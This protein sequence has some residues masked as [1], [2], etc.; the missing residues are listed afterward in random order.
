MEFL[1]ETGMSR[2][3]ICCS[4]PWEMCSQRNFRGARGKRTTSSTLSSPCKGK[5]WPPNDVWFGR[6]TASPHSGCCVPISC[7]KLGTAG[8]RMGGSAA[9]CHIR[10]DPV[11]S[12]EHGGCF[13]LKT[14]NVGRCQA[15]LCRDGKA[16]Q[17][18]HIHTVKDEAEYQRVRQ[19]NAI[20]TEVTTRFI[21]CTKCW[22]KSIYRHLWFS[23]PAPYLY[24]WT[25]IELF[26][27]FETL[28]MVNMNSQNLHAYSI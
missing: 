6:K 1:M 17:L 14:A 11:A 20:I 13:T 16:M 25:L 27:I 10:H 12:S 3:L 2:C 19:H 24:F 26:C 28:A 21:C 9:L 23:L 8:Q 22:N 18:S 4:A 5:H 7:R 15:V